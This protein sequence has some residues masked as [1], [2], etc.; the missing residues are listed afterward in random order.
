VQEYL[1]HP[2]GSEGRKRIE[3][4]RGMGNLEKLVA[5]WREHEENRK[6]LQSRTRACAGCGVRVE[7]R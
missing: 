2:E 1:S 3:V 5:K 6:W 7:K 4:R